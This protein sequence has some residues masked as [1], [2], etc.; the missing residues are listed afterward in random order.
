M[1]TS[2]DAVYQRLMRRYGPQGWWPARGRFEV[3]LG[4]VLTQ[5]TAWTNAARAIAVLKA[6]RSHRAETLAR[7]SQQDLAQRIR[8]AGFH[9][10]KA[11]RLK[12][13]AANWING[14]GYRGLSRL[15]TGELRRRLLAIHGIGRETADAITLY[16]FERRIFVID[17]YARRLFSRIGMIDGDE[18]YDTLRVSIEDEFTG[19]VSACNE[20]HALIVEHGKTH[21]RATPVCRGCCLRPVCD[22]AAAELEASKYA[23]PRDGDGDFPSSAESKPRRR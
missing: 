16:A 4:A 19:G 20:Y 21:C 22:H 5:G 23:A 18:A 1:T 7:M 13:L 6:T 17:A 14:G 11:A 10:V 9:N 2:Y 15:P 12:A 8:P 3:A